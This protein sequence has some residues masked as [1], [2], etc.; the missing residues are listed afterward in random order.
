M[1]EPSS[2]ARS[3]DES[4][5]RA[6]GPLLRDLL[7]GGSLGIALAVR[8]AALALAHGLT[9]GGDAGLGLKGCLILLGLVAVVAC[10]AALGFVLGGGAG[11]ACGGLGAYLAPFLVYGVRIQR[12]TGWAA[13]F[14]QANQSKRSG[15]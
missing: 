5:R 9:G 4:P 12:T 6:G 10:G 7:I 3:S 2:A 8:G 13:W 11:A 14:R 1:D 15:S